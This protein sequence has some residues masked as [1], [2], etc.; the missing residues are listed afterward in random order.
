MRGSKITGSGVAY[1]WFEIN[2]I[3]TKTHMSRFI[4]KLQRLLVKFP[5]LRTELIV[6]RSGS[7]DFMVQKFKSYKT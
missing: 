6:T 7:V 4:K 2:T 5:K 1:K 3:H